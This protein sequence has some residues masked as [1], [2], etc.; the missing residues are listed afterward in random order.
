MNKINQKSNEEFIE[1]WDWEKA[2]PTG[3]AVERNIAHKNGIAHEG[4]H[5]WVLRINEKPELLF[6]RRSKD[7]NTFPDCLDITVGGH[8]PFGMNENKIQKESFEEIGISPPDESLIDL[9]WYRYEEKSYGLFHREFQQ[10]FLLTDNRELNQYTFTD[11]EVTAI[12]AIPI[13][14]LEL[15]LKKDFTFSVQGYEKC[16]LTEK[17]VSRKDFHPLLFS[18]SMKEYMKVII[19]A[20]NDL[21]LNKKTTVRMPGI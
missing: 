5:L 15:L 20:A 18:D 9:G 7:K 14:D 12:F 11:G 1:E 6:Q 2:V 13:I 8:V 19:Q 10:V 17:K 3:R 16:R 21:A 4:V